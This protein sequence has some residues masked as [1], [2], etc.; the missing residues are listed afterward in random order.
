VP[1]PAGRTGVHQRSDGRAEQ[2]R[3]IEAPYP[4]DE[5]TQQRLALEFDET[6]DTSIVTVDCR[7]AVNVHD[8]LYGAL[9]PQKSVKLP[10]DNPFGLP[11]QQ[12]TL[13]AHG[14][15]VFVLDL[16]LGVHAIRSYNTFKDGS[17]YDFTKYV[18]VIRR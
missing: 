8:P 2:H 15:M 1:G 3:G 11:P 12:I 17:V 16:P 9:S 4:R 10:R 14:W 7:D 6:V 5:A 13:S 18:K